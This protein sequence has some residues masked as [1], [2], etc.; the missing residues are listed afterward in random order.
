MKVWIE[1]SSDYRFD[2]KIA[3]ESGLIAPA[4]NRYINMMNGVKKNDIIL[5]YIIKQRAKK[6]HESRIIAISMAKSAMYEESLRIAVDLEEIVTL[7]IPVTLKEIK[8]VKNK[9]ANLKKLIRMS[10]LRYLNEISLTDFQNI[11]MIHRENLESLK[12]LKAYKERLKE[13]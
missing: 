11:L 13:F 6:E 8:E 1:V 4:T 9:S 10:F 5:H 2:K 3:G 7:P 12:N